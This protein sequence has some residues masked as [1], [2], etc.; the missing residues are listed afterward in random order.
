MARCDCCGCVFEDDYGTSTVAGTGTFDD[1]FTV[2]RVDPAFVRPAVKL[3]R[4]T[5]AS[6]P[7]NTPTEVPW[8]TEAFDTDTMWVVGNATRITFRTRGLFQ[9][10]ARWQWPSNTTGLRGA[11]WILVP[12]ATGIDVPLIDELTDPPSGAFNRQ[13]NYQWYFEVGDYIEL[14]LTQS[15]GGALNLDSA[16][17]WAVYMGRKV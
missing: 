8:V 2:T 4:T 16:D 3:S 15:S 10:G 6:V 9:F 7:N 13:L 1:P 12:A 11:E 14:L 5:L 17:G